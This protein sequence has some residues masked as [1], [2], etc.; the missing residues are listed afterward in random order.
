V[1]ALAI[2][3]RAALRSRW[4]SWLA[5][6]ILAGVLGGIVIAA[7]AGAHRTQGSYRRY[8][9]SINQA[10]VYVDPFVSEAGDSIPLGPVAR[11]PEVGK[12]ERSL[13]LAAIVRSS[14]GRPV[15]PDGPDSIGWVLPTDDRRYDSID[16]MK[17]LH[18]RLPDPSRPNEVIGD[19]KALSILGV[20]VGDTVALRTIRQHTL[21][22]AFPHLTSN[23]LTNNTGP[24]V[25]LRVVGVAANARA[26]VDGGQ[27]H[28]TPA[29][30]HAYG[31]RRIGAFIEELVVSLKRGQA[32]L[33]AFKHDLAN[34]AGKRPYLMFEPSAGHPKI[35]HSIDLEARA[36]WL[37]A[38][39][40]GAA[41]FVL[42]G[43]AMLRNAADEARDD[44]TLRALGAGA[45]H[46]FAF[47]LARG[48]IIAIP[49]VLIAVGLAYAASPLAPIG[50]AR[51][52]EPDNGLKFDTHV[53][54]LGAAVLFCGV[55][56]VA[57]VGA[58]RAL[59]AGQARRTGGT[60]DVPLSARLARRGG[61]PAF[62]AG[63]RMAFGT[64]GRGAGGTLAA[65]TVAVAVCVMALTFATSFHHLTNTPRLY[66][67][68]WDYETFAG[69]PPP[70]PEQRRMLRD[71]GL[72]VVAAGADSTLTVNG[73][74]TG[75]RAWDDLKGVLDPTLT[76]GRRPRG[77]DEV[78]LAAKTLAQAHAQV[79]DVVTVASGNRA[80][81]LRV[82]GRVVLPSSKLNK[83]G[84]GG[85]MTFA[86][87]SRID[88]SAQRGLMLLRLADGPAGAAA[89]RRL[90][91][92]FDSNTVVKPDEVGDFGRISNMPLF[93]ALL[94]VGAAG[95]ALAHAL[96][97]R[98]RR[99]QRELAILKTLG[100]TRP[101]VAATIAWQATT[102]LAV[103]L[104]IGLPLGAAAGRFT[105]H[106]FARDLGVAPEVVVPVVPVL[107]LIPAAVLVGNA[108]A[109][110][111]GWLAARVRPA[112]A[113]RTE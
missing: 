85:V 81:R 16:R 10:D 47:A 94:A 91:D 101:Q 67:Q 13:Q 80:R 21:D 44:D 106:L 83:L 52:L 6:A 61:T 1:T 62:M 11:L 87:L 45:S 36:L 64:G 58:V 26:D 28:L 105:W 20:G 27:M 55:L 5:V 57:V 79:G 92:F 111:P 78:A 109:A 38:A 37:V 108:L 76:E 66:G 97:T 95:A 70:K 69:P 24:L 35:Q 50:W 104:V 33:A 17:L 63:V 82:V 34:F 25:R 15:F 93:I 22:H 41:A 86:A 77:N 96:V 68:T 72:T 112:P 46:Q 3:L 107:L 42:A 29:F 54:P 4:R 9:D 39:L 88:Q 48:L 113:L 59:L 8:L 40:F 14:N 49:A 51:E 75:F 60:P 110:P 18:G 103:A 30:F 2:R 56:L 99:G 65:A 53:I 90:D 74:D 32:S 7:A 100:F 23:P 73:H 71:P 19:T 84:Y 102:I 12:T 43:Q 31:E 89:Q 98:V